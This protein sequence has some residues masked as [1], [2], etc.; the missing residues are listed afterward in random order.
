MATLGALNA[1]DVKPM[2]DW[3]DMVLHEI[4]VVVVDT[5]SHR[6]IHVFQTTDF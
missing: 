5:C 3:M 1:N 2:E 4:L 6:V